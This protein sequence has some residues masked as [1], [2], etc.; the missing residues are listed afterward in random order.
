[1]KLA[2]IM[3]Y[4]F[5]ILIITLLNLTSLVGHSSA[6]EAM[7]HD[8]VNVDHSSSQTRPCDA[9][10]RSS[11]T[12]IQAKIVRKKQIDKN[13]LEAEPFYRQYQRQIPRIYEVKE[14]VYVA[15]T[16]PPPNCPSYLLHNALID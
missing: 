16:K 4:A 12:A 13:N 6:M 1:M 7:T 15:R 10:C 3:K 8:M 2:A 9:I 11:A 14:L 5:A